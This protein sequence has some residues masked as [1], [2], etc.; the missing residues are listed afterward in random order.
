V[1]VCGCMCLCVCVTCVGV[2]VYGVVCV[3]AKFSV[4][5]HVFLTSVGVSTRNFSQLYSEICICVCL[6]RCAVGTVW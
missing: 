5:S 6:L 2:F 3:L 1:C 4:L